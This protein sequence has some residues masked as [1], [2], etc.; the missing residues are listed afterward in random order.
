MLLHAYD[1]FNLA[2]TTGEFPLGVAIQMTA[3]ALRES[4]GET[5]A[6]AVGPVDDS[7]GVWQ[8]NMLGR[9]GSTRRKQFGLSADSELLDPFVNV[10]AARSI[11]N[12]DPRNLRIAWAIDRGINAARYQHFMGPA[13]QAA[14]SYGYTPY[15]VIDALTKEIG[16][17]HTSGSKWLGDLYRENPAFCPSR[18]SLTR[19][20]YRDYLSRVG[21]RMDAVFIPRG[22]EK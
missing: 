17:G 6:H 10:R 1:I 15:Q 16:P 9:L 8:I 21:R 11:W 7:Y 20:V 5:A 2:H 22:D 13:I 18:G 14:L 12:G 3:I 19:R 4:G